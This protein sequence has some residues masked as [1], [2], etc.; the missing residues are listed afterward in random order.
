MPNVVANIGVHVKMM[1]FSVANVHADFV[2]V[3]ITAID[4]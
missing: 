1:I 2:S 4:H 3:P